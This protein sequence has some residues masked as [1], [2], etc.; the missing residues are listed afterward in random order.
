MKEKK[1]EAAI[2]SLLG[3]EA[4][5]L[6]TIDDLIPTEKRKIPTETPSTNNPAS[7]FL[8]KKESLVLLAHERCE[9]WA[10]AD[11]SE[12]E[13]G[14]IESL[15]ISIK[16]H[17]QQ[18]PILVRPKSIPN[19]KVEYEI[20][21]GNRRWRACV[22]LNIPVKAIIKTLTDQE[23]AIS[24]KEENEN[25]EGISDYSKAIFYKKM[26]DNKIFS[27]T[28]VLANSM[29]IGKSTL[30]DLLSYTRIKQEIML[31]MPNPH[32]LSRKA[33]AKLAA[34]SSLQDQ[35][36]I[37]KLVTLAPDIAQGKI[38][39][40][41]IDSA[42]KQQEEAALTQKSNKYLFSLTKHHDGGISI[43]IPKGRVPHINLEEINNV[44]TEYFYS[45][46]QPVGR[47]TIN[48]QTIT[49]GK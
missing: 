18:E 28:G 39:A 8:K 20:I 40:R 22:S 31:A 4:I 27:S 36:I 24:Q 16:K 11:R 25:R 21:F 38:S 10:Y 15:A 46:R 33:A 34:L 45:K 32:K 43:F 6:D 44:L 37:D 19:N 14:D 48:S 26:L 13:M 3:E 49:Q 2:L 9:P 29:G 1:V 23:A 5:T 17:G 41:T 7:E 30:L 42:L 12:E 47:P 35:V